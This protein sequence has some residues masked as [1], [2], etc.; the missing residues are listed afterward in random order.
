[1]SETQTRKAVKLVHV[2]GISERDIDLLLL[3]EFWSCTEFVKWFAKRVMGPEVDVSEFL[4]AKRS[5]TGSMGESDLEVT[6]RISAGAVIKVLIEN[7]VGA[8]F[9]KDQATRYRLRGDAYVEA[10][11]CDAYHTVLLAPQAYLGSD[12]S[13]K[14]FDIHIGYEE[15][16]GWFENAHH[17]G[18]RRFYKNALLQNAIEKSTIGYQ[19]VEDAPVTNFWQSYFRA[20]R[21]YA[22]KLNMNFPA[23]VPAGSGFIYLHPDELGSGIQM[24]HK[25]SFG[26]VDLQF[27]AMGNKV[28]E[29]EVRFQ[30]RIEPGM[31]F[32]KAN[33]SGCIRLSV[34]QLNPAFDFSEQREAVHEAILGADHLRVWWAKNRDVWFNRPRA[35]EISV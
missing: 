22:P 13:S 1:M 27:A 33:K 16:R 6:F 18:D 12:V 5:V 34:P 4:G 32:V 19:A 14:G 3:E 10:S 30:D 21:E 17:I 11:A 15:L 24:V 29:L 25:L 28:A 26:A 2:A 20:V 31:S 35:P 7:K 8:S 9:Q 23:G